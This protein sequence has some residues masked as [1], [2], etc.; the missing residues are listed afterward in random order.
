MSITHITSLSQLDGF[1]SG[2]KLSVIDFHATWC[3]PC[4]AIAPTFESLSKQYKNVNF[5]KCDVD[6]ARDVASKYSVSAMPTFIFLKGTTKVDQVRGANKSGLEDALKRHSSGA[7]TGAAFT[8]KGQTLGS[9]SSSSSPSAYPN[10]ITSSAY[11]AWSDLDPK[12]KI[13]LGLVA[14]YIFFWLI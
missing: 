7:S 6:A 11:S 4:H 3:G 13:L 12:I 1:L 14:A 9:S 5:L 10:D 2:N 8:G